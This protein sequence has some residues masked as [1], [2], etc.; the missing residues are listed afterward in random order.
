MPAK[1]TVSFIAVHC[2]RF[3]P[4]MSDGIRALVPVAI[5]TPNVSPSGWQILVGQPDDQFKAVVSFPLVAICGNA[6]SL[7]HNVGG[8]LLTYAFW[9]NHIR[10]TIES[11]LARDSGK[12]PPRRWSQSEFCARLVARRAVPVGP[13]TPFALLV[14]QY[15]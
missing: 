11:A 9:G 4:P 5:K 7:F 2:C 3:S 10:G 12:N 14:F 13:P 15:K 6:P 1:P 8:V